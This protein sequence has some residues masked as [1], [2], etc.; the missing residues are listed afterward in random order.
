MTDVAEVDRAIRQKP[1]SRDRV[2]AD[3]ARTQHGVVAHW[4]LLV[5]GLGPD[6]I[7]RWVRNGRLH[8]IHRGVY[9]VG[10][11]ALSSLGYALAAALA[12][13]DGALVGYRSAAWLWDVLDDARQVIDVVAV[14]KRQS[15]RGIRFH[16]TVSLHPDDVG[17]RD[18]VPVT[19]L[20]RT[21]LDVAEVVPQRRLVYAIERAEKSRT[22]DLAAIREL[23]A[24][25]HG[26]HGLKALKA[27]LRE[28]E[29]EAL[30]AHEGIERLFIDFC[31]RYG[32]GLPAMNASV[33]GFTVDALWADRKLIVELDSW[34]HHK[35][36]R[37]FEE[38]R[39]RDA[40]LTVAGYRVVRVTDRMLRSDPD[41]L[42][43][44]LSER[45]S[46]AATA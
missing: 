34:E 20:A 7:Q 30:H 36:R 6:A 12:Y 3:L 24:R 39:R 15:R 27:A 11:R 13:G 32:L 23:L 9:A 29:P 35:S 1:R 45:P 19:S 40:V 37:S 21:L 10:H 42:A 14:A 31:R 26:R 22:F 4:Q 28:I 5:L 46:L 38:D 17:E 18:G 16:S 44:L 25:S 2:I 41:G 43:A 33:E 8:R